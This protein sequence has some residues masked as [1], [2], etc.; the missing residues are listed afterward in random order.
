[1]RMSTP[2]IASTHKQLQTRARVHVEHKSMHSAHAKYTKDCMQHKHSARVS[3]S[4]LPCKVPNACGLCPV[5]MDCTLSL[6]PIPVVY[7]SGL[8]LQLCLQPYACSPLPVACSLCPAPV[9]LCILPNSCSPMPVTLPAECL[10][11]AAALARVPGVPA[12]LDPLGVAA[13]APVAAAGSA[14]QRRM[15][16]LEA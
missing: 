2:E 3:A 9:T 6:F 11:P 12:A 7:A 15:L 5:P 16:L 1:M 13:A 4:G 14:A 8:C 10:M